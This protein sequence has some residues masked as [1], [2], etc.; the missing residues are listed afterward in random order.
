MLKNR[1]NITTQRELNREEERI[2]KLKAKWL[3]DSGT[4]DQ[5]EVGTYK[6]LS[7]I[8]RT[9][10][11]DI[12]EFAGM[13]RDVNIAKDDFRFA[14]VMYLEHALQHIDKMPQ[15]NFDEIVEKYVEMN[16]AHP[17]RDG[18]VTQGHTLKSA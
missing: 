5:I 10:F 13:I 7:E 6:G 14:P 9:L 4:L 8:H 16:I 18:N 15:S 17:F 1:L 2:T 12:Y 11:E 3:F